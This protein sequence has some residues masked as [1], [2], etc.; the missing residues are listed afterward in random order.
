MGCLTLISDIRNRFRLKITIGRKLIIAFFALALLL[1]VV[2]SISSSYL[3]KIE[4]TYTDLIERRSVILSNVLK[5]QVAISKENSLVRAY[6]ITED[7]QF[8]DKL[9][10]EYANVTD[11]IRDTKSLA[12]DT[13]FIENLQ[14]LDAENQKFKV[15]YEQLIQMIQEKAPSNQ[16][17]DHFLSKVFPL[18][19][20]LDPVVDKLANDQLTSMN[21]ASGES[22][23]VVKTAITN[24]VIISIVGFVFAIAIGSLCSR[25]ISKPIVAIAGAAEHIASGD[26]SIEDLRVNTEDEIGDLARSFNQMKGNLRNLVQQIGISS[27]HVASSS[28]ELTASS[29]QSSHVSEMVTMTI[30]EVSVNAEMQ[31]RSVDESLQSIHD[32]SSGVQHIASKTKLTSSLTIETAQ[33]AIDGNESIQLTVSQ[34]E[35][36]Q[37]TM[38]DLTSA[39]TEMEEQSKEIELIIDVISEIAAQTNL[40]SLNAAL[41]ASRA[42]EHGRGFAVVAAEVRKLAEQSSQ[43]AGQIAELVAAINNR[44]QHVVTTTDAGVK[45]VSDGIQV[46]H[47]AGKLFEFIKQNIDDVSNQVQEIST[48]SQQI[49]VN[50]EQVVQSIGLISDGS[51]TVS[52]ESQNLAA[53]TEEQLASMEEISSSASSLST[54]AEELQDLVRKFKV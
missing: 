21:E 37:H 52:A 45:K 20:Q 17:M 36:I 11:L 23:A 42:G 44:T 35:S 30:Q 50:T 8:L 22:K 48:A 28:E 31:S 41:E 27:D 14:S 2:G 26:L 3:M 25:L 10:V 18:G 34:M 38:H 15:Q 19:I 12:Q 43:S 51:R 54:M 1:G 49:A 53:A 29:E 32:M 33:K 7:T 13:E 24:V 46:A 6:M 40:L 16:I 39:V 4:G 5:T 9:K 47:T